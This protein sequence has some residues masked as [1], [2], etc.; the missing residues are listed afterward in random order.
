R[1][2]RLNGEASNHPDGSL[3]IHAKQVYSNCPR[4][5]Q[6][7]EAP[8]LQTAAT[9]QPVWQSPGQQSKELSDAQAAWIGRADT[10]F[11]A[12]AHPTYGAD[13]SHR[14]GMP[15]FV[16]V[17]GPRQIAIPGYDGNRMFT[18][19]GNIAAEPSTGLLFPDFG[20]GNVLMLTGRAWV[21][22]DKS[23]AA[24]LPGAQRVVEYEIDETL[25]LQGALPA[26]WEFKSYSPYN[27]EL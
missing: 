23:R 16:R 25:E 4:Y 17:E 6:E 12:T 27:P 3:T 22:W 20:S 26:G 15:G 7:R 14:G 11:I 5:I 10:L 9:P 18:T 1:R 8:D 19:L 21:N 24:E 13:A 2:V